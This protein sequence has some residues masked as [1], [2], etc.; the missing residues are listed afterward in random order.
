MFGQENPESR[1]ILPKDLDPERWRPMSYSTLIDVPVEANGRG[2]GY[3]QLN[4][5]AI[6]ITRASCMIVGNTMDPETSGLYQDGQYFVSM[7][8]E[9]R[10]YSNIPILADLLWGPKIEG[11][12][13][14]L[15]YPLM[16]HA[17]HAIRFE[18]INAYTRILTPTA[19]TFRIQIVLSGLADWGMVK[20]NM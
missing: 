10:N 6:M 13:R 19:T 17:A 20:R 7:N 14:T 18:V 3:V 9:Q 16:Y 4:E 5:Q 1:L 2:Q 12:W 11:P 15:E 8:D